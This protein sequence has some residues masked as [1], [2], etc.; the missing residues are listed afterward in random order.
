MNNNSYADIFFALKGTHNNFGIVTNFKFRALTQT[1]VY[2]GF[3]VYNSSQ[4]QRALQ[5]MVNFNARNKDP[6]AQIME[7]PTILLGQ[8]S[9]ILVV[10]YDAPTP[11]K[12]MFDEFLAIPHDGTFETRS[13]LSLMQAP[14]AAV[15]AHP[16]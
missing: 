4:V 5:A 16:R 7:F 8:L 13:L 6:R 10:S 2:G 11:P 14:P 12:G 3:L 15:L 1:L 9:V